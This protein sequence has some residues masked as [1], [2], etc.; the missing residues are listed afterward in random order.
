MAVLSAVITMIYELVQTGPIVFDKA[1]LGKVGLIA[2]STALAYLM[3]NLFE[4][5][6]GNLAKKEE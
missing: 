1:F 4:N 6:E 3:K 2:L 5:S